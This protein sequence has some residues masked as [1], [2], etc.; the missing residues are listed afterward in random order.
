MKKRKH[1]LAD[2]GLGLGI[3]LIA[4]AA[5]LLA[6]SGAGRK[7]G[8]E[9]ADRVVRQLQAVMP[10][11][12][13]GAPD[14]RI[15][16]QMPAVSLEEGSFCG[17]LEV[18]KFGTCLPIGEIWDTG[19]LQNWPCKY[20][21]SPYGQCLILGGSDSRL[22]FVTAVSNGDRITVTDMTG[23]RYAYTV[24][25]IRKSSDVSTAYL[26][27]MEADLVIFARNSLAFDYTVVR[28]D[29]AWRT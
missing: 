10:Q 4:L 8:A 17:L 3:L 29:F 12:H 9:K 28:C 20:S 26:T 16:V 6:V 27:S 15:N 5:V 14:D 23:A 7:Q 1:T 24:T 2:V 11:V 25:D 19:D 22:D 18:P 13:D 21:G